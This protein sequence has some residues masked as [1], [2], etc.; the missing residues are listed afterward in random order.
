MRIAVAGGTGVIGRRVAEQA[1]AEGHETVVLARAT[2]IDLLEREGLEERL[3]GV[4]TVIDATSVQTMSGRTS[5]DFFRTVAQ[6]DPCR[7]Y[8]R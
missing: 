5:V 3:A 4:D 7:P 1:Q 8:P 2:G 6:R